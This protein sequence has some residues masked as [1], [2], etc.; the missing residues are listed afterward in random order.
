MHAEGMHHNWTALFFV[1]L[2]SWL[3]W[4]VATPLILLLAQRTP[5]GLTRL[6]NWAVHLCIC[7]GI[8]LAASA[9]IAWLENLWN[10]WAKIPA[11]QPYVH[12]WIYKF[13]NGLLLFAMLYGFVLVV[14]YVL[15]S[16]QRLAQQQTETSRLNE[17]LSKSQLDALRRQI[18]PH[19]LFNSLNAIAGLVREKQNDAAVNMIA[20]LSDFLRRTLEDSGRQQVRLHEEI[21]FLQKYL[22]IQKVRFGDRLRLS[23]DIPQEILPAQVPSLILQL[24]VENAVKHGISKLASGGAIRIAASRSN[25]MLRLNVYNDGPSLPADWEKTNAGIGLLN[26]RTRLRSLYGGAF[27]LSLRNQAPSGVEVSVAVPYQEV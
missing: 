4:A 26:M 25:G 23:L 20:A 11:T 12:L 21:D 13:Y 1:V 19:F 2:L 14:S 6:A 9:W 5:L 27:E 16:R 8:G 17:Q 22:D 3:P 18:E 10:P 24:M 15:H 7:A